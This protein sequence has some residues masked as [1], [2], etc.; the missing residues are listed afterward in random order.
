MNRLAPLAL[1]LFLL[2]AVA[3]TPDASH[4]GAAEGPVVARLA[5]EPVHQGE[6]DAWLR[7]DL[8]EQAVAGKDAAGLHEFRREGLERMIAERLLE[9]EAERQGVEIEALHARA[10]EGVS[11]DDE[12]LQGFYVNNRERIVDAS[13][14]E[15]AP[16]I[17]EYL[18]RQKQSEAWNAY[19]AGLHEQA[20]VEILL[21]VPRFEIAPV[22]PAL[23]P[24]DAPVTIVEF[25]DFNCPFCQRVV[26]TLKAL[27]QRYPER[28][29]IVF[30]HFPLEMH[31][32][33]RA[34]AE[35]AVC[36][37]EQDAFW[38]FHDGVFEKAEPMGDAAIL[39]LAEGLGLDRGAL[40]ACLASGR[41]AAVVEQDIA[42]GKAAG[43][44]GTPAFFVNGIRLSGAQPVDAFVK[45]IERE[46]PP[47]AA[48][49]E[50]APAS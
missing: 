7:E 35:A 43:V 3:C 5:G 36:A 39:A 18:T 12:E 29:R 30:R 34:I 28:L 25:S 46:L 32:R 38:A 13:F 22:G 4:P 37:D 1:A 14:E 41:G 9:A 8:F 10:T 44:T 50:A 45:L 11:V 6:L 47:T 49:D 16:R 24:A 48:A 33:A 26:P 40:E 17:R 31:P 42:D 20:G 19:V 23:G 15:I 21:E 2:P 27:G